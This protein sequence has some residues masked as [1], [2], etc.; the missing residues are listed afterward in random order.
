MSSPLGPKRMSREDR[1]RRNVKI[2]ELYQQGVV[3]KEIAKKF[4]MHPNMVSRIVK[5]HEGPKAPVGRPKGVT[6]D[7]MRRVHEIVAIRKIRPETYAA[8]GRRFGVSRQCIAQDMDI[9]RDE[10]LIS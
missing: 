6:P 4:D 5:D 1:A 2:V 7:R 9:A 8:L 3:R 10:G